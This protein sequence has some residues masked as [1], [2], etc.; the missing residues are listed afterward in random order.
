MKN[1]KILFFM[2][3][4]LSLSLLNWGTD[5]KQDS[6]VVSIIL[7][8]AGSKTPAYGT[9][10][11]IDKDN[12][13]ILTARHGVYN[14][15]VV[16]YKNENL[17][18]NIWITDE[19]YIDRIPGYVVHLSLNYDLAIIKVDRQF[20]TQAV[21]IP[22]GFIKIR[23]KVEYEGFPG[24]QYGVYEGNIANTKQDYLNLDMNIVEGMSGGPLFARSG[25]NWL[26]PKGI[27]GIVLLKQK[28]GGNALRSENI[29]EYLSRA[30]PLAREVRKK[31]YSLCLKR[32]RFNEKKS[33]YNKEK[34]PDLYFILAL[35]GNK[36]L[37]TAEIEVTG[38]EMQWNNC[39][40][41]KFKLALFPGD[42]IELTVFE[43]AWS[44]LKDSVFIEK[45][46]EKL[47]QEGLPDLESVVVT[48]GNSFIFER[49]E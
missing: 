16:N 15:E 33:G 8:P 24:G 13:L 40:D 11:V 32:I 19:N 2:V 36:I 42:R 1:K 17:C 27:V 5:K 44:I 12:G 41:N 20:S 9:G 7:E 28:I 29:L 47:P 34:K 30:L 18:K 49:V 45:I 23:D 38:S 14:G 46:F 35:N 22:S 39:A 43:V 21:F 10:I 26:S 25:D 3:L 31:T 6:V 48:D 37:E 4:C